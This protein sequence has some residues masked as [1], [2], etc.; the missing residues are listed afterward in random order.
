[1]TEN[2]DVVQWGSGYAANIAEPEITLKGKNI[3]KVGLSQD[4]V[5]ALSKSGTVYSLPFG[6]EEQE[7]YPKPDETSWLP[8]WTSSKSTISY[9]NLTPK[10]DGWET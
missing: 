7:T 6:K 8:F 9:R 10:L 1:M 3:T 5:V 2:G 4:R